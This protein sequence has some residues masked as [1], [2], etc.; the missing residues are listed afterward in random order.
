MLVGT[1]CLATG[2]DSGSPTHRDPLLGDDAVGLA[3]DG[4]FTGRYR[5]PVSSE[6]DAAAEFPIERVRWKV[7]DGDVTLRYRLPVG[8]VGGRVD[9]KLSGT[10]TAG[11]DSVELDGSMGIG[12]CTASETTIECHETF[13]DLGTLPRDIELVKRAAVQQYA[14][15]VGDRVHVANLFGSDPIGIVTIDLD[16]PFIADHDVESASAPPDATAS[17]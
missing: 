2:S 9:V 13:G 12:S 11:A 16:R 1:G 5:V 7:E 14:G 4:S 6:L 17:Y 15:P 3:S 10:L 8:L